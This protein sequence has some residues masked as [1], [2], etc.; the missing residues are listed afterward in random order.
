[1]CRD[2][3]KMRYSWGPDVVV[4]SMVRPSLGISLLLFCL[5][6]CF[7]DFS[8][9]NIPSRKLST[10]PPVPLAELVASSRP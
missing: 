5:L 1:M 6:T 8:S 10:S 4:L 9:D 2:K 7:A 3:E